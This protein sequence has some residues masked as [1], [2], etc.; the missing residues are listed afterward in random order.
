L[1]ALQGAFGRSR[2]LRMACLESL[3]DCGD[4]LLCGRTLQRLALA[5]YR[6]GDAEAAADLALRSANE[7]V[8][9]GAHSL[10]VAAYSV[11]YNV[12]EALTGDLERALAFADKM[13]VCARLSGNESFEYCG[14]V[15]RYELLAEMA[16]DVA[17]AA[18]RTALA[19]RAVPQQYR[20]RFATGIGDLLPRAWGDDFQ[21][22][23]AGITLLQDAAAHSK[24]E[25]ALCCA[26]RSLAE[27]ALGDASAARSLARSALGLADA[28]TLRD[29]AP[30][31]LRYHVLARALAAASC[32]IIGDTVRGRRAL[33]AM[34]VQASEPGL[35]WSAVVEGAGWEVAAPRVRGYARVVERARGATQQQR[36]AGGLTRSE[37]RIL[38]LLADG[39]TGPQIAVETQRSIHTVRAQTRSIIAKLGVNGRYAAIRQAEALGVLG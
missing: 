30:Y 9:I 31:E 37:M 23:R 39:L 2:E 7:A 20:E 26:L 21:G 8:A 12:H 6:I 16:D 18:C 35:S 29:L 11:A 13:T 34:S 15:A 14:L 33:N 4:R 28:R 22:F 10:A 3:A 17:L 19:G 1:A 5:A 36:S 25:R 24:G 32:L 38:R 27:A